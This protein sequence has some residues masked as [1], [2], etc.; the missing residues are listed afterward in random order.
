MRLL[1]SGS[2]RWFQRSNGTWLK[3]RSHWPW[4][5]RNRLMASDKYTEPSMGCSGEKSRVP[6]AGA[7]PLA[8]AA[9]RP[10]STGSTSH[11]AR[12]GSR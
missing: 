7:F 6:Q 4:A 8:L 11:D 3:A 10:G 5:S 9:Y 12:P 1:A 2:R